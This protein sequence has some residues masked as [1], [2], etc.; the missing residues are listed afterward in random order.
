MRYEAELAG[1]NDNVEEEVVLRIGSH[2]ITGFAVVC[3]YRVEV[4]RSYP[5]EISL[6]AADGLELV[7]AG[8]LEAHPQLSRKGETYGYTVVGRLEGGILDAGGLLF[9][10]PEFEVDYAYLS[11]LVVRVEADRIHVEFLRDK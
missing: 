5:V 3:P 10:E 2:V 9:E 1:L 8:S 11:G 4:G 7:E 6:W